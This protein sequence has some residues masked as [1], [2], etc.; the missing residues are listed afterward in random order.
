MAKCGQEDHIF[1]Y[2]RSQIMETR[3][4]ISLT[5]KERFALSALA[6]RELR[7]PRDQLRVILRNELQKLGLLDVDKDNPEYDTHQGTTKWA[8]N[9]EKA[10]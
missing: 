3:I 5:S 6:K 4:M 8:E 10:P 7:S 1:Y 9:Q 2:L